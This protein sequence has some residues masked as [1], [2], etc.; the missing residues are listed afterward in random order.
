M[1]RVKNEM[2][3]THNIKSIVVRYYIQIIHLEEVM[4]SG[5]NVDDSI[6]IED[7][8]NQS[9]CPVAKRFSCLGFMYEVVFQYIF[10]RRKF[11]GLRYR[12]RYGALL[13]FIVF[14]M[15]DIFKVISR[16]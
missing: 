5:S 10:L 6:V 13:S 2:L 4:N 8:V 15:R 7:K 9:R 12:F 14:T 11:S 3:V 16:L 1:K